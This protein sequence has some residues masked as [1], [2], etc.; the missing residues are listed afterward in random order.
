MP[1]YKL[2]YMDGDIMDYYPKSDK[3]LTRASN[4]WHKNG[5]VWLIKN[6]PLCG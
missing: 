2:Q 4:K 5:Y 6:L 3:V 1:K